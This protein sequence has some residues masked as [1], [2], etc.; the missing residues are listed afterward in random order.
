[1]KNWDQLTN[2]G[3]KGKLRSITFKDTLNPEGKE[4]FEESKKQ[5]K[6]VDYTKL[7]WVH[8]NRNLIIL[9]FLED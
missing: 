8:T 5:K 6:N 9:T 1:M 4:R 2:T 7:V 3:N